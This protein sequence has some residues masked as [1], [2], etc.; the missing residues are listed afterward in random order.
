ME[1][2]QIRAL[3]AVAAAGSLLGASRRLGVGRSRLRSRLQTL[4]AELGASLLSHDP[5]GVQLTEA[6]IEFLQRARPLLRDADALLRLTIESQQ[7]TL[8]ELRVCL[9]TGLPPVAVR[10]LLGPLRQRHPTMRLRLLTHPDPL[11]LL[12]GPGEPAVDVFVHFGEPPAT[13]RFRTFAFRRFTLRLMAAPDYLDR[14]G[15]P[16]CLEELVEHTLLS[17]ASHSGAGWSSVPAPEGV[18]WAPWLAS[19][20]CYIVRAAADAGHGIALLP[21]G[22]AGAGGWPGRP[23]ELVLPDVVAVEGAVRVLLPERTAATARARAVVGVLREVGGWQPA[24]PD[25]GAGPGDAA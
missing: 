12:N 21:D 8:D 11:N 25:P 24:G 17:W 3:E 20:D 10:V 22:L 2:K 4:E 18:E 7:S 1:L 15:R 13:G 16:T 23:L 9:P 14:R 6:G 5:S 19:P